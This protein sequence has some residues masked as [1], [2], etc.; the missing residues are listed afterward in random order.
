MRHENDIGAGDDQN[1]GQEK[2]LNVTSFTLYF[3]HNDMQYFFLVPRFEGHLTCLPLRVTC[4]VID[5]S[6]RLCA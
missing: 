3:I 2:A 1:M 4:D 6:D 5:N